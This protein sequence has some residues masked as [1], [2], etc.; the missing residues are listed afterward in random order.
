AIPPDATRKFS[1]HVLTLAPFYPSQENPVAGCFIAEP[2][3]HL[4]AC[5]VENTVLVAQPFYRRRET[6]NS[7]LPAAWVRFF[8]LPGGLG[9]SSAGLLLNYQL[10]D[11]VQG[12]SRS[13]SIDLIHAHSALPCGHAAWLLS[14]RLGI[15]FVVTVH[16]LDASS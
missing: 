5:G 9:L 10:A 11:R 1:P 14:R 2:R 15:P 4:E 16:G 8:S 12:L 3:P 13:R 7:A 6:S